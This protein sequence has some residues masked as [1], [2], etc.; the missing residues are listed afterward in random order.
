VSVR[1][2]LAAIACYTIAAA[3]TCVTAII[4]ALPFHG[5]A[6]TVVW[7]GVAALVALAA[8]AVSDPFIFPTSKDSAA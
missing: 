8:V 2:V 1:N 7:I 3:V 4:A 5:P 6:V